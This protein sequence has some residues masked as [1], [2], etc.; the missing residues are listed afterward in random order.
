VD[1]TY[2]SVDNIKQGMYTI[3]TPLYAVTYKGNTN[4]NV[5]KLI[6]WILSDEGQYIIEETGYVGIR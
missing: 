1:G 6:E 2:P 4:K 3:I 5:D